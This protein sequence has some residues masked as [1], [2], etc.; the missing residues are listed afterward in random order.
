MPLCHLRLYIQFIF[1]PLNT[2]TNFTSARIPFLTFFS[3]DLSVL[4]CV[5]S[6]RV[7]VSQTNGLHLRVNSIRAIP[8]ANTRSATR[9]Y[10]KPSADSVQIKPTHRERGANGLTSRRVR[11]KRIGLPVF[12]S[13]IYYCRVKAIG[14][15]RRRFRIYG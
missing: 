4:H 7:C 5:L 6:L 8:S 11:R 3:N 13:I 9:F 10:L 2:Y 1:I 14:L 12:L 15:Y